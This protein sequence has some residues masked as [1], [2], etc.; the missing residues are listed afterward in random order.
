MRNSTEKNS[1]SN[2]ATRASALT[3]AE[4]LI[5]SII[6]TMSVVAV[7]AALTAG[8]QQTYEAVMTEHAAELVAAMLDEVLAHP[9]D[10]PDGASA[11][12]PEAGETSRTLFD[13]VDDYH[14]YTEATG[15]LVD[16]A[17]TAYPSEYAIYDRSVTVVASTIQPAGFAQAV[18]GLT[19]TV[20][21]NSAAR[22][23]A[24]A[25]RFVADPTP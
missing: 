24:T 2:R 4:A 18:T 22:Q 6:L 8:M 20:D 12:G 10:D 9:Y 16:A 21:V 5:A 3:L 13:N 15:A 23:L 14:G 17:G 25:S 1:G 19:V 7:S 11:L